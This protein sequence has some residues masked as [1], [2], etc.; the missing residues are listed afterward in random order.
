M[1]ESAYIERARRVGVPVSVAPVPIPK[2]S[3]PTKPTDP[4]GLAKLNETYG[5]GSVI[6]IAYGVVNVGQKSYSL[7]FQVCDKVDQRLC[8]TF[9]LV[10]V[11]YNALTN[12]SIFPPKPV[13]EHLRALSAP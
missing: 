1:L 11:F 7:R 4:A 8:A 3:R 2:G 13:F 9:D 5:I 12:K 10:Q 6:S